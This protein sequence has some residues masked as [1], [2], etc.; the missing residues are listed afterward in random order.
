LK[1]L[2]KSFQKLSNQV[3][4]LKGS[5]K[6]AYTSKGGFRPPFIKPFPPNQPNPTTEG[7]NFEGLHYD[8]QMIL[9]AHDKFVSTPLENQ[10]DMGEEGTPNEEDSSP[11]I[12]RHF[13]N[14]IFQAN[15]ETVHPYNT[16]SKAQNKLSPETSR[17]VISKQP[18]K[19]ETRQNSVA[20]VLEYDLIEDLKKL[21]ENIS[22]FELLKFPPILQKMVQSIA[23]NN[24]KNN[25]INKKS[26]ESDPNK[27][28]DVPSKK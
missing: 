28:K 18:K 11:P 7:L 1:I 9:E 19:I 5:V 16:R 26:T 27:T 22:V 12:F 17:N 13:S 14:N 21:R 3:I 8:F 25:F 6:E 23:K 20:P 10:D 4:Y 24:K 15:F 2:Q